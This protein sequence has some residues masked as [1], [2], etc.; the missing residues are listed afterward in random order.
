MGLSLS[1]YSSFKPSASSRVTF[2]EN[3]PVWKHMPSFAESASSF[4]RPT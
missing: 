4:E 3:H 1:E 2:L